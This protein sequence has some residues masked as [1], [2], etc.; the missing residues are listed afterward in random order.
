MEDIQ[1]QH[2]PT[3][4]SIHCSDTPNGQKVSLEAIEKDHKSRGFDGIGYHYIIQPNGQSICTRAADVPGSHVAMNNTGNI[5]ICLA[6][7]DKFT[8]EQFNELREI[9]NT[10][11][12]IYQIPTWEIYCH[13]EWPTARGK[14]CPNM[15]SGPLVLWYSFDQFD[16]I[17]KYIL[18]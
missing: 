5:G 6:G 8:Y 16:A 10:L 7:E 12:E 3:K 1:K 9:L 17:D 15:R 13:N 18:K 4:I 11:T 14:T 2:K